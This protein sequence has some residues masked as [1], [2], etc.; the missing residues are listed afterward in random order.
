MYGTW[1]NVLVRYKRSIKYATVGLLKHPWK[2]LCKMGRTKSWHPFPHLSRGGLV[3]QAQIENGFVT[4][5]SESKWWSQASNYPHLDQ[6]HFWLWRQ[7]S[8]R[9]Q[10]EQAGLIGSQRWHLAKWWKQ[11]REGVILM[12]Q[13]AE[14][15]GKACKY[16]V[17][18]KSTKRNRPQPT[19]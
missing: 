7:G 4:L 8:K 14:R 13:P 2:C 11:G 3:M 17:Y 9:W 16:T 5:C 1:A 12:Q 18:A 19:L 6:N 10:L 15:P